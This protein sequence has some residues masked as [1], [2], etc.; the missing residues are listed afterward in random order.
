MP[1]RSIAKSAVCNICLVLT[2]AVLCRYTLTSMVATDGLHAAFI[3]S[4]IGGCT[5][6][7]LI[8]S[9][10][11]SRTRA[12]GSYLSIP[13]Y[14]CTLDYPVPT[15]CAQNCMFPVDTNKRHDEIAMNA[16]RSCLSCS[17]RTSL[18]TY[19]NT[20]PHSCVTLMPE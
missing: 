19:H 6:I 16:C 8:P 12:E 4:V 14:C 18:A 5:Q 1:L 3:P 9:I 11:L 7:N 13:N 20:P 17:L 2:C 10:P 15:F